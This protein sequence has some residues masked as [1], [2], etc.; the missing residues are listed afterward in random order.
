MDEFN[1]PT[2]TNKQL[3]IAKEI[4]FHIFPNE[5]E[6]NKTSINIKYYLFNFIVY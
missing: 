2:L 5:N 1:I 3:S 6:T 4:Y